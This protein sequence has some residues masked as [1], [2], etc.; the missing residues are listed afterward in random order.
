MTQQ[1]PIFN[2][3]R[4]FRS[5]IYEAYIHMPKYAQY[6]IG[7]RLVTA[8]CDCLVLMRQWEAYVTSQRR[9]ECVEALL[10]KM[11]IIGDLLEWMTDMRLL[12]LDKCAEIILAK[13]DVGRQLGGLRKMLL[14]STGQTQ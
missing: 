5:E 1:A 4:I 12:S 13:E 10:L 2:S 6:N 11:E 8:V 9:L 14:R 7:A 3:F